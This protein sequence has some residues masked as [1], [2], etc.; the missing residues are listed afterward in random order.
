MK[1][2]QTGLVSAK[3]PAFLAFLLRD[4]LDKYMA[5]PRHSESSREVRLFPRGML[6]NAANRPVFKKNRICSRKNQ[7]QS[8]GWYRICTRSQNSA[9]Q[10]R[11]LGCSQNSHFGM[12][13][14]DVNETAGG[15]FAYQSLLRES[16]HSSGSVCAIWC[17]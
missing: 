17:D 11:F 5:V 9:G 16:R 2:V 1:F 14:Q 13:G 12:D 4:C 15:I 10:S 3:V 7:R 8:F 6:V